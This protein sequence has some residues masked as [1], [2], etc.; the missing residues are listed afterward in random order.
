MY[1]LYMFVLTPFAL[2]VEIAG[3]SGTL[4]VNYQ[5]TRHQVPEDRH[6]NI[7]RCQSFRSVGSHSD[8]YKKL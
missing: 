2:K 6:L 7:H 4:I 5:T 3:S 1:R 8:D